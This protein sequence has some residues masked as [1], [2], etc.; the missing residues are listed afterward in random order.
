MRQASYLFPLLLLLLLQACRPGTG[1]VDPGAIRPILPNRPHILWLVA[2]DIGPFLPCYGDST[3]ATP[4]LGRLAAEGVCY[5]RFF[6]PAPVCAPARAAIATGMYPTRIGA[7]HMRTGPWF[8]SNLPPEVIAANTRNMPPDI[9]A[10]E[11]VP[12]PE[13]RM[14]SEYLRMAGYYCTNNAKEDYQFRMPATAWDDSS[15][16][17]HWRNRKPGQPFF[18]VFN[19]GVTHE[20]QIWAK[21]GDSLWV[22]ADLPVPVPPYLPDTEPV[23][24][25]IRRLYSNIVE[26]DGQV[27]NIL[28]QLE[29]D[30]LLDS[31][32]IYW[33]SDHG[34]PLPRQKRS[35]H[36]SGLKAP[37][38]IRFPARQFAGRRDDRLLSFV[39]LAPTVLSMAG[40]RPPDHLD[41][42]AFAGLF[43]ST[44]PR[45]YVFAAAD[46]FDRHTDA[47]RAARDNRFKYI[48]YYRPELPMFLPVPYRDQMATMQELYRLRDEDSLTEA[49]ALWFRPAKPAEEL[50]DTRLDPHEIRNLAQ[51]P[52]YAA[53][54][55]ELRAACAQ[56][57][58]DTE[59]RNLLP[60]QDLLRLIWPEG[61]Q[62]ATAVPTHE[63]QGAAVRLSCPTAGAWIGYQVVPNDSL[64]P[65]GPWHPYRNPVPL[66]PGHTLVAVAHRLGFLPGG[67]VRI[68]AE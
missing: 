49:Q 67:P 64:I 32:V 28:A 19:F 17:A 40:I 2:E 11:A 18:A 37:M 21:A 58:L 4:H 57:V 61:V 59:D 35:L 9:P 63:R 30:G 24:I 66:P 54:L 47:A 7:N 45:T 38:I 62:P 56:W 29:A 5:D 48:R 22:Q 13:V 6:T 20:S 16:T 52:A 27:G 55:A 44:R 42:R 65:T 1:P 14:M 25:D 41:G 36:D 23:R 51:N 43:P 68:R 60:E 8:L 39:D 50:F 34:G 3:V 26:M 12:P 46:R 33:Y 15:P 10:Y 31:T 53:N